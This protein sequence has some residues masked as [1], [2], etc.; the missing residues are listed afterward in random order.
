MGKYL[1]SIIAVIAFCSLVGCASEPTSFGM[2]TDEF[3]RLSP[4]QQDMIIRNYNAEQAENARNAATQHAVGSLVGTALSS[5]HYQKTFKTSERSSHSSHCYQ[6]GSGV[7][8]DATE[9]HS[10]SGFHVGVG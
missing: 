8:C 6:D 3:N 10:S 1:Y 7:H 5:Q 4:S 9:T 2:P